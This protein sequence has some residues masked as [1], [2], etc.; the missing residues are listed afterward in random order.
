M[1]PS[2]KGGHRRPVNCVAIVG[3]LECTIMATPLIEVLRAASGSRSAQVYVS[4]ALTC[5]DAQ[6]AASLRAF[7]SAI[8]GIFRAE[9]FRA[10]VPHENGTDPTTDP[11]AMPQ[12]V[13]R[14]DM[15]QVA[16]SVL[17]IAYVGE[18]SLGVGAEIEHARAEGVP[19]VLLH[20][21]GRRV[22]RLILGCP[23]VIAC[24]AIMDL[25]DGVA[26]LRT[27]VKETPQC[28]HTA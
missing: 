26:Q 9:S 16:A 14:A 25:E 24:M 15:A 21:H 8:G 3:A 7:Y 28:R 27:I 11:E 2:G 22:S 19:V 23:A 1:W 13:Y 18:P 17:V 6:R 20:E 4:G 10:Y 12:E 5:V